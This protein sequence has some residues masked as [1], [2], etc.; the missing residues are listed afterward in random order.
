MHQSTSASILNTRILI[1]AIGD[2]IRKLHPKPMAR[3]R[4]MFVV[5]VVAVLT[6]ILCLSDQV[7]GA[8]NIGL[9]LQLILWLCC[10]L[11]FANAVAEWR[12]KAQAVRLR[13]ARSET[14]AKPLNRDLKDGVVVAGNLRKGAMS[15]WWK[16]AISF[17]RMA[18]WS[19]GWP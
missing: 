8:E 19:G 13:K 1:P 15:C 3:N 10:T 6:T 5:A 7:I 12:V 16:R 4:V 14:R 17:A 2:A 9:S 11:L 18:G